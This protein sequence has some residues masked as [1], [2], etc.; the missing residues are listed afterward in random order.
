MLLTGVWTLFEVAKRV[1][2]FFN[3]HEQLDDIPLNLQLSFF[4]VYDPRCDSVANLSTIASN[5]L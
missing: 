5:S 3:Q 2:K 1:K 4:S